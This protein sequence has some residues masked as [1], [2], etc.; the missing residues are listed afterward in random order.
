MR[1][2]RSRHRGWLEAALALAILAVAVSMRADGQTRGQAPPGR[3]RAVFSLSDPVPQDPA[4]KG[5]IDLHAH[6][7]P[8]SQGPSY[9]Q[10]ARS[11]DAFD[12]ATRAKAAGM[13]GF[14]IKQHLDQTAGLAYYVRKI[15]PDLEVFGGMG[16][17]LTTGPKVNPWAITHMAEIKGGWGRIVWMPSWDSEN[18]S[19]RVTTR[20]PPAFIAVATCG[21]QPFWANFPKPCANG[22]LLPEVKQALQVI[23]TTKTRDSNGD[24]VL[25]TGHNS[26]DEV[27][28]M[29]REAVK[30]GVKRIII[31][32]PLLD[33]VDM[34]DAEI[35]EVVAMGPGIYAEFTSQFGNPNASPAT[36]KRHVSAIRAAGVEHAFVSTDVGQ[37][38]ATFHPD[39][40]ANA[41]RALRAQGFT[42]QELDL[43]FKINPATILGLPVPK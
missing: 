24:L 39:A 21:N 19:H 20:K 34:N 32:H 38:G 11:I 28:L 2:D 5:A 13:R 42:E 33:I 14:V 6:Q 1:N 9:T 25:A 12:L 36:V 18:S 27:V 17:N 4:L 8:D 26:H 31:T 3:G 16:S 29:V 10:A 40:L 35:K 37:A 23:A 43:L 30:V 22:E 7:D 41:A 15:H